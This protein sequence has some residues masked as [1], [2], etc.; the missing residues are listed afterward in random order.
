MG[1]QR[2]WK[3][4]RGVSRWDHG[5]V[6]RAQGSLSVE[7]HRDNGKSGKS[8]KESRGMRHGKS[9]GKSLSG[10]ME[11]K[12]VPQWDHREVSQRDRRKSTEGFRGLSAQRSLSAT[13]ESTG[14]FSAG[15][16]V[17]G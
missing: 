5:R 14:V 8:T 1:P 6:E 7:S 3:E 13:M 15:P 10:T 9:A 11:R 16:R 12:E 2:E 17:F 4:H